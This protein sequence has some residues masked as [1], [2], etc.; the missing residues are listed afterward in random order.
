MP[1]I[2]SAKK[3]V[4]T[5]EKAAIANSKTRKS[6]RNTIK[7]LRTAIEK[8][9]KKSLPELYSTAQSTI[10]T[11]VKKNILHKNKAARN[12]ARLSDEVKNAGGS[13]KVSA[14]KPMQATKKPA[15]AKA[16]PTK[17]TAVK[18]TPAKKATKTSNK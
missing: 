13:V 11:A 10:D 15:K 8:G 16:T 7:E 17:K 18:K 2:K 4:K 14:T 5:A 3:R 9:D 12:K 6:M 1:I